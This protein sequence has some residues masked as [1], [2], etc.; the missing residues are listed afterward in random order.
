MTAGGLGAAAGAAAAAVLF[1]VVVVAGGARTDG[2]GGGAAGGGGAVDSARGVAGGAVDASA[3]VRAGGRVGAVPMPEVA[4]AG[5]EPSAAGNPSPSRL[6]GAAR[7]VVP[8]GARWQWPVDPRP[9]VLRRFLAPVST[10]GAGHRG[11]DLAAT[12][13]VRVTAVE[14]GR[15]THAGFVAGRGTVTVEHAEGLRSTYE[16]V[17]PGVRLGDVVAAGDTL[18]VVQPPDRAGV[19]HHCGS[20]LCV[21]LGA[22][23]GAAYLDPLPLLTV[24]RLALLPLSTLR[25]G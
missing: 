23:L 24:G 7:R 21:H 20:A 9:L 12:S 19:A 15:V 1:G 8:R 25:G 6:G 16:P 18:G 22:R 5:G 14:S 2:D 17:R 3:T 13:G 10:Y 4:G 11:L